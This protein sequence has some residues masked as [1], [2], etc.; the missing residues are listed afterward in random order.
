[1]I[2][3][4]GIMMIRKYISII[5]LVWSL[6]SCVDKYWPEIDKYDD[7]LVVDGLLTD[8]SD[9]TVIYLSTSSSVNNEKFIPVSGS[10]LYILDENQTEVQL[11]ETSPGTY[12]ILDN[13]FTGNVGSSYQLHIILANG[14]K[15]ES[16]ICRMPEPT[17]LDS[18]YGLIESHQISNSDDYL[19]GIQFYIDNH[20]NL[21][22]TSYYLW[23]LSQS[24]EY[25]STFNIDFIWTGSIF[26][27]N[28]NPDSLRTCW[29]TSPVKNIF[30]YSTKY[31]D[32]PELIG[33]PINYVST[34]NKTL[35]IRYSLLVSQL[36][37]SEQAFNFW[38]ALR[39]QNIEKNNLYSQQPF[40][41]RGNIINVENAEEPV[42]GYF[43]V[44]GVSKK[45]IFINR[46]PLVFHYGECV[47]DYEGMRFIR[48]E[49]GPIY[50]VDVDGTKAMGNSDACF[51]CRL[52]GGTLTPP[53]F[54][55][56]N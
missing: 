1:M 8:G 35:S 7:V 9:T 36:S 38:D 49:P 3:N 12:K 55:E 45:R 10:Q 15:Y 42:L 30:T 2:L 22:D 21:S 4:L 41:I 24:F 11:T 28:S 19:D 33:F 31:I 17:P 26:D 34:V 20:S 6:S 5:L 53:P 37:I 51:D 56:N 25:Q 47:P 54:W 50:I 13:T 23:R 27:P 39:Q 14:K 48:F 52:E 40:Q 44:A 43:T 18:V 16:D 29:H 46:P 32:K